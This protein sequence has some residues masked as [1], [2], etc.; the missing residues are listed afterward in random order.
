MSLG[1]KSQ[2]ETVFSQLPCRGNCQVIT[3]YLIN[4]YC[5]RMQKNQWERVNLGD[6][7]LIPQLYLP[8]FVFQYYSH[9]LSSQKYQMPKN[10]CYLTVEAPF[11]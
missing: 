9:I 6:I 7:T 8:Y 1:R 5:R 2:R 4:Y 11:T 3:L 10:S